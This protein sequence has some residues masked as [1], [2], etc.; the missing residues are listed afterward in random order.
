[1]LLQETKV[2]GQKLQYIIQSFKMKYEV[3]AI[4]SVGTSGGISILWN[5]AETSAEGWIGFPRILTANFRQLGSEE[6]I[7]ILNVYGPPIPGERAAFLQSI[8]K[9]SIMHNEDY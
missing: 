6:N 2:S 9:L 3:V 5:V 7:L 1:M 8:R 4:D